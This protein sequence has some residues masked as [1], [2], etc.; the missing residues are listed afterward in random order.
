MHKLNYFLLNIICIFKSA[1][2]TLNRHTFW[3]SPKRTKFGYLYDA[4]RN[5]V[6]YSHTNSRG[7]MFWDRTTYTVWYTFQK[8]SRIVYNL[9]IHTSKINISWIYHVRYYFLRNCLKR[10]NPLKFLK[11]FQ[12]L[13]ELGKKN[14]EKNTCI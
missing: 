13:T 3:G 14:R 11:N 6:T 8:Y 7:N 12:K 1:Q 9:H 5:Q 4:D 10:L 2:K